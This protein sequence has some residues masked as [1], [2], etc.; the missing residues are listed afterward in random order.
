MGNAWKTKGTEKSDNGK[1]RGEGSSFWGAKTSVEVKEEGIRGEEQ[2]VLGEPMGDE[3]LK[4]RV[5][6]SS[7][8]GPGILFGLH[9]RAG[10]LRSASGCWRGG[11]FSRAGSGIGCREHKSIGKVGRDGTQRIWS[12]GSRSGADLSCTMRGH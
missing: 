10:D 6:Y 3:E 9:C 7:T 1:E 5:V 8:D 12:D 4:R 11:G 2:P